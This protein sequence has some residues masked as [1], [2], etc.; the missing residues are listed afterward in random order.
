MKWQVYRSR[1]VPTIML[2][3]GLLILWEF[4]SWL[5][6]TLD[7]PL[8]QSKVPYIHELVITFTQYSGTLFS[9]GSV[10]LANASLGF[11]L[12]AVGGIVLAILM[13]LTKW[14][15]QLA[16]PYAVASQMIPILGLAPIVYG[17]FRDE[18]L[19]RILIAAY[20]TF[21]PVTLNMLRGLRSAEPSSLELMY[22][23]AAKKWT[24]Y[25]RLRFPQALPSL[26]TGL[27]IAAPLAV[28]GAI[29]VELMG[30]TKGLGVL[31]LRNLYYGP[32]HNYMFWLTVLF[33]AFLGIVSYF[34]VTVI[35]RIVTPWQPEFRKSGGDK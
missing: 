4:L 19:A 3:I 8:A 32:S 26:F 17:I 33:A 30:A 20:T 14:L 21:F 5:L 10:T 1:W 6:L 24:I 29:L 7:V 34:I 11:L 35:E 16:F 28:T 27:K 23:Y 18:Q 2:V 13:S 9:E 22:S 15:E 25:T 12:G 31:M